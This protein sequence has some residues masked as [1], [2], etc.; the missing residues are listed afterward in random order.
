MSFQ[1][2]PPQIENPVKFWCFQTA[3]NSAI[4]YADVAMVTKRRMKWQLE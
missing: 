1:L 3:R 2:L 4:I